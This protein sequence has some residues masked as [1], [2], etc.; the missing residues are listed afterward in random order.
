MEDEIRERV[1]RVI[2]DELRIKPTRL[3]EDTRSM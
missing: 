1:I 3:R 2:A